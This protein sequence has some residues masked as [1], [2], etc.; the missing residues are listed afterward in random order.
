M[1]NAKEITM[2]N[3]HYKEHPLVSWLI[4][5][6]LYRHRWWNRLIEFLEDDF[7]P[8]LS[9]CIILSTQDKDFIHHATA[10]GEKIVESLTHTNNNV[11]EKWKRVTFLEEFTPDFNLSKSRNIL[12]EKA[13]GDIVIHRDADTRLVRHNFTRFAVKQLL[14]SRF[15]ILSFPSLQ[16]GVHF[17]PSLELTTKV[18][19][20]YP[21]FLLSNTANGM[22]TALLRPI[23][24]L[25]GGRNESLPRWGEHTALCAK[26]AT[27]GFLIGY[28]NDGYWFA[29]DDGES[30]ISLTDD[31]R[32]P[33]S[34]FERQVVTAMLNDFYHVE[35]DDIFWTAQ[36]KRYKVF[37]ENRSLDVSRR[38]SKQF[39]QFHAQQQLAAGL[40]LFPFKPWDCLSHG[41]TTEFLEHAPSV[42]APFFNPIEKHWAKNLILL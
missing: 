38:V 26:L 4:P 14:R 7:P 9:E 25:M 36:R 37:D 29:S 32:N 40:R 21:D 41:L 39:K 34:L 12:L 28:T 13:A 31:Q 33:Q 27:A 23:E 17:K 19:D 2:H 16:N 11:P 42:A 8:Q 5:T 3:S 22:T 24:Q 10:I 18:D 20:R 35:P 15:G 6:T 1:I 30:E